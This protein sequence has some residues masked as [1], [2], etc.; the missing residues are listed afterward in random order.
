MRVLFD[1]ST[2]IAA[3][4]EPHPMHGR[5]FPWLKEA[6]ARAFDRV[7]AG[8]TLAELYAVLGTLLIKPRIVPAVT[9]HPIRKNVDATAKI[10]SLTPAE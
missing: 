6:K 10:V 1:T 5:A 9:W 2:L 8:H 7:V 4:V 3:L